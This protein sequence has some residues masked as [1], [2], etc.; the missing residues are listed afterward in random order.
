MLIHIKK[1]REKTKKK[2]SSSN[3]VISNW[4]KEPEGPINLESK[5]VKK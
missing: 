2:K 1:K 3:N 5:L 4:R